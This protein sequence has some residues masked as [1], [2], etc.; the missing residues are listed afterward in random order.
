MAKLDLSFDE[1]S[2]IDLSV[3]ELDR[4]ATPDAGDFI[5]GVS[6][7]ATVSTIFISLLT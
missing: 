7:G 2:P 5:T 6:A 3:A 4:I 1:L